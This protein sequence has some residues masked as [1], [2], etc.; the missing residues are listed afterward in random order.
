MKLFFSYSDKPEYNKFADSLKIRVKIE[1][2]QPGDLLTKEEIDRMI[3]MA[4]HVRDQAI[5][6]AICS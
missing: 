3:N 5:L 6:A 2:I 4:E 1:G